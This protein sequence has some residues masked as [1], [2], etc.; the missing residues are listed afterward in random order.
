MN[1]IG[2]LSVFYY[3]EY[4]SGHYI[5]GSVRKAK[6]ITLLTVDCVTEQEAIALGTEFKDMNPAINGLL[7]LFVPASTM[8]MV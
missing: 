7:Y 3:Q 1:Q 8:L 5:G 4:N 6:K 2:K